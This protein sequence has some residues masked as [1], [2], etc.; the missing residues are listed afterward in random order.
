[1]KIDVVLGFVLERDP[2]RGA[3]ARLTLLRG[4]I[5]HCGREWC[6]FRDLQLW[7]R[8]FSSDRNF[9]REINILN[10][11]EQFDAFLHWTLKCLSTGD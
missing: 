2:S 8:Y 1:M 11:I 5:P 7:H 10:G 4:H 9:S 3:N 6:F